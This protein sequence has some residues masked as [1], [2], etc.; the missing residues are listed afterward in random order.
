M[1]VF[2]EV[3]AR[4][5]KRY[6]SKRE[7]IFYIYLGKDFLRER[8]IGQRLG[9]KFRYITISRLLDKVA[10]QIRK[11]F[12][13]WIDDLNRCYGKAIEW[14]FGAVSSRNIYESN[15]FQYA[16]YL[17][18][19]G[20]LWDTDKPTLIFVESPALAS[21]I[22]TWAQERNISV[23]T[24]EPYQATMRRTANFLRFLKQWITFT[25]V[26][27]LRFLTVFFLVSSRARKDFSKSSYVLINTFMHSS[28]FVKGGDFQDR[29]YPYLYEYL[30][31]KG[32]RL[33]I[34]PVLCVTK[35]QYFFI[36]AKM[37]KSCFDF[38]IQEDFL[39][40]SD[41]LSV[42]LYPLRLL[43]QRIE[44]SPFNGFNLSL[45]LDE[46]KIQCVS[47][48]MRAGLIYRLC[49][50]LKEADIKISS[51]IDWYENQV[52]DKAFIAG[53]HAAFPQT[54]II[55]AQMFVHMPNFLNL[56]P[57]QS[58]TEARLI[59]DIVLEMSARQ[60]QITKTYTQNVMCRS[61]AALR[62][63]HIFNTDAVTNSVALSQKSILILLPY[64]MAG[65]IELLD[66]FRRL[67]PKINE[68]VGINIKCHPD[69]S[70]VDIVHFFGKT[71]W[72]SRFVFLD[73][74]L[75]EALKE[76][77]LVASLSSSSIFEVLVEG[78]PVI[79]LGRQT[80][81]NQN[82]LAGIRLN[83]VTECFSCDEVAAALHKYLSVTMEER[84]I[85][86]AEGRGIR[87]LFFTPVSEQTLAP[88]SGETL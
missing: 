79:F 80:V 26:L 58:E 87:D 42:M 78:I 35:A 12:V 63:A 34:H 13:F 73:D 4:S 41:Y 74:S 68:D 51:C 9:G 65:A 69:Y 61:A 31:K 84:K 23:V 82:P 45:L 70:N 57:S 17:E 46:D 25:M 48:G 50:R 47:S 40:F 38:I 7:E 6:F 21:I 43:K 3:N 24:L 75:E 67:L 81:L 28:S 29:Y 36:Y 39:R 83:I 27:L 52:I 11:D 16:C 71:I 32:K 1:L 72:P 86:K 14:W 64:E 8:N 56:F 2:P 20:R 66:T 18:V 10:S 55:G 53:M 88:F 54:K 49:R 5:L 19:L 44:A 77:T 22:R 62:Y 30:T 59:P 37:R 60:C 85:F 76:A 33:L 15:L